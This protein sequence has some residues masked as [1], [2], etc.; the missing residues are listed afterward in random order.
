[1]NQSEDGFFIAKEDL[2]LRGPGDFYGIRQ[3][4]ELNFRLA[5]I[6]GD[7]EVL[8][9]AARDVDVFLEQSEMENYPRMKEMLSDFER[10]NHIV[11]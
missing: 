6:I 2:R 4:G 3:S 11:L 10:L 7:S 1:M 9:Q 8:E 5:D